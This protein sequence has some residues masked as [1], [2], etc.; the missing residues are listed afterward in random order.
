MKN[1]M[2]VPQKIKNRT[3]SQS[4]NSTSGCLLEENRNTNL[5]RYMH[6][7]VHCSIICNSH[8]RRQP[9]C[10]LIDEWINKIWVFYIHTHTHT[11][12]GILS[13]MTKKEILPFATWMDLEGIML[14]EISQTK[15]DKYCMVTYAESKKKSQTHRN[16]RKV[17]VRGW[18]GYKK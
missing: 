16:S 13:A 8:D 1:N 3:T 9:K 2:E 15:K 4:S 14:S 18:G 7:Y 5:K 10:L 6:H 17:V 12:N 11:H